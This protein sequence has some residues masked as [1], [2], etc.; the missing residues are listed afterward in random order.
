MTKPGWGARPAAQAGHTA[1]GSA[2]HDAHRPGRQRRAAGTSCAL[3]RGRCPRPAASPRPP[4]ANCRRTEGCAAARARRRAQPLTAPGPRPC[5]GDAPARAVVAGGGTRPRVRRPAPGTPAASRSTARSP[6]S[7]DR[8]SLWPPL[9]GLR[10]ALGQQLLQERGDVSLHLDHPASR[11]QISLRALKLTTQPRVLYRILTR[12][13]WTAR[14]GLQR[15]ERAPVTLL[16]PLP[17][18]RAIQPFT[19]HQRADLARLRARIGLA[20]DRQL[21]RR[22]KPPARTARNELGVR[23]PLRQ[24]APAGRESRV[25]G[26]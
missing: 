10:R 25:A 1:G 17:Q 4:L 12:C 3:T 26:E 18:M 21:V 11:R 7:P 19:A 16:T 5:G 15:T 6:R 23:D 24:G 2:D 14:L 22:A 13:P 20:H 8:S 9:V